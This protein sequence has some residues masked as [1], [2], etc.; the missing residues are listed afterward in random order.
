MAV[1]TV[2]ILPILGEGELCRRFWGA[3]VNPQNDFGLLTEEQRHE[4]ELLR[5]VRP[6]LQK[7]LDLNHD[8]G[9]P[10]AGILGYC[11]LLLAG[12]DQL[13]ADARRSLEIIYTCTERI[14]RALEI[15]GEEKVALA[16]GVD[17]QRVNREL[18]AERRANSDEL[19]GLANDPLTGQR[20]DK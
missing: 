17:L 10:L 16:A 13:P 9:N 7:C 20:S 8:I 5:Q 18:E 1:K 11:E 3:R 6:Y 19:V 15:L 2:V 14:K 12:A 4:L